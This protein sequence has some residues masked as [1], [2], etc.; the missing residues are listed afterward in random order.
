VSSVTWSTRWMEPRLPPP[1]G[2]RQEPNHRP[3]HDHASPPA[4]PRRRRWQWWSARCVSR[5][6]RNARARAPAHPYSR[7]AA[8]GQPPPLGVTRAPGRLSNESRRAGSAIAAGVVTDLP[9]L[10][11]MGARSAHQ[12]PRSLLRSRKLCLLSRVLLSGTRRGRTLRP[13][14]RALVRC[15]TTHY[16][17]LRHGHAQLA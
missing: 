4:P 16:P 5:R 9:R 1:P 2:Y 10:S 3:A 8:A 6:R 15:H 7:Q 13:P 12:R 14:R 11:L 17:M